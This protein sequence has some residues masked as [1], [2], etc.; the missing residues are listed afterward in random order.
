L[1]LQFL[2]EF[3]FQIISSNPAGALLSV[4]QNR[5]NQGNPVPH[6]RQF[7]GDYAHRMVV[8]PRPVP[9]V[10]AAPCGL[11]PYLRVAVG[12]SRPLAISFLHPTPCSRSSSHPFFNSFRSEFRQ[13]LKVLLPLVL[14][15]ELHSYDHYA[16]SHLRLPPT[17][18]ELPP[19]CFSSLAKWCLMS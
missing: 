1:N 15:L 10:A 7:T 4:G 6:T 9:Q 11:R 8:A 13:G 17:A 14:Q 16:E 19:P 18:A 5:L 2:A 12:R 3:E